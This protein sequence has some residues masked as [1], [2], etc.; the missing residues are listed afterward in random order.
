MVGVRASV[1]EF[2]PY[3]AGEVLRLSVR[4][5]IERSA[6]EVQRAVDVSRD[7]SLL[8]P[9]YHHTGAGGPD[10]QEVDHARVCGH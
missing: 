1:G 9:C 7:L 4:I 2:V 10:C 3:V 6:V 5:V 8:L